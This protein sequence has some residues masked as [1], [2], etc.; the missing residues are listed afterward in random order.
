M[1]TEPNTIDHV[2]GVDWLSLPELLAHVGEDGVDS[3]VGIVDQH[4][5]LAALLRVDP[6]KQF[7]HVTVDAMIHGHRDWLTAPLLDLP[8]AVRQVGLGPPRDV[9]R[10]P[11]LANER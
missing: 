7:L 3:S 8:S 9:D 4:V 11:G 2:P 6:L 10:G 1:T 5:Q